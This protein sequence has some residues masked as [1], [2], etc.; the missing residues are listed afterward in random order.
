MTLYQRRAFSLPELCCCV[1]TAIIL[2]AIALPGL[3]AGNRSALVDRSMSNL[4]TLHS[5]HVLYAFDWNGR[6]FTIVDDE[7]GSY[8]N[9]PGAAFNNFYNENGGQG[10]ADQHAPPILGWGNT[11]PA[12]QFVLFAYRT[13][14]GG[15]VNTANCGLLIPFGFT[16][17]PSV[18]RLGSSRLWNVRQFNQYVGGR[19]YD[20]AFYAPQDEIVNDSVTDLFDLPF[21]YADRAP[22]PQV[23][24][25]P[26]WAGYTM[27]ASAMLNPIVMG[28]Q[29]DG[30]WLDPWTAADGLGFES[31]GYFQAEFASL[32]THMLEQHWLQNRTGDG[33]NPAFPVGGGAYTCEPYYFNHAIDSAPVT[34]FYDGHIRLLPNTE[35]KNADLA[36]LA[37]GGNGVWNRTTPFGEDGYF[38]DLSFDIVELSHH[39]LTNDG[40][41]GRDTIDGAGAVPARFKVERRTSIIGGPDLW[42]DA[43]VKRSRHTDDLPFTSTSKSAE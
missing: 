22:S 30:N 34:L 40:I 10:D 36:L 7:I 26:A 23:G 38:N 43:P 37:G 18:Q 28:S 13:H 2:V 27:S 5:A 6:Q 33:C 41:L 29:T 31:P 8:G 16:G 14:P 9:S 4:R 39:V 15:T 12:G 19:F 42:T 25:I 1:T 35:V 20:E 3:A 24:D 21:E 11:V 32:K 17:N